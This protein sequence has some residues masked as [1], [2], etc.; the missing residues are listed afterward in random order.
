[1]TGL[2]RAATE[3]IRERHR[4]ANSDVFIVL[5]P[6]GLRAK[7]CDDSTR[8]GPYLGDA[9]NRPG[10]AFSSEAG[11]EVCSAGLFGFPRGC[12][13]RF[14]GDGRRRRFLRLQSGGRA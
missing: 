7:S 9:R 13:Q 2:A 14:D 8:N 1:M 4:P 5:T 10:V 11:P 3:K 6:F 12:V